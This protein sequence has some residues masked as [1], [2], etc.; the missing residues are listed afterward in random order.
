MSKLFL[1]KNI[2][3]NVT[4]CMAPASLHEDIYEIL[5]R[6]K[7]R[8]CDKFND[9]KG[10]L[11]IDHFAL[12]LI[13]QNNKILVFS[14]TPSV[15]YNLLNEG[16]WMYDQ[17]FSADYQKENKFYWWEKAYDEHYFSEIKQAKE[18]KHGFKFGVNLSKTVQSA[19]LIY[20]FAT[21]S[22][23]GNLF[24]YYREYISE[25]YS[26]GDYMYNSVC[27]EYGK[28]KSNHPF[29]KLIKLKDYTRNKNES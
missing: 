10:I 20:S 5:F 2:E 25:L 28:T 16:L 7:K 18:L 12:H 1:I 11:L 24:D 21:R 8:M 15:E 17:A 27:K 29:L 22:Q 3:F 26:I 13:D 9:I 23:K 6:Y 19:Q 4:T 14:V